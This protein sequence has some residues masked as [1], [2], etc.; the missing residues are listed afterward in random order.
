MKRQKERL[1]RGMINVYKA[2]GFNRWHTIDRDADGVVHRAQPVL[3]RAAVVSCVRLRHVHNAKGPLVVQEGFSLGGEIAAHFGPGDFRGWPGIKE[4]VVTKSDDD[5]R[6]GGHLSRL[7]A[8]K[9]WQIISLTVLQ[10][11]TPSPAPVLSTLSWSWRA[12]M[13]WGRMASSPL[14]ALL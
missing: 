10:Q 4:R 12:Q 3:G 7:S 6:A 2:A 13:G 9:K 11:C 14:L 8:L 1:R 5:T